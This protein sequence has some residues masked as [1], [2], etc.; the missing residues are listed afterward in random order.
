MKIFLNNA[1]LQPVKQY[2]FAFIECPLID[3]FFSWTLNFTK[4]KYAFI[5]GVTILN[6]SNNSVFV[7]LKIY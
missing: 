2:T 5:H 1:F 7:Y 6:R 3:T 4:I